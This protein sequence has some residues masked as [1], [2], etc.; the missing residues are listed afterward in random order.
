MAFVM[1]SEVDINHLM[2]KTNI[3]DMS[4]AVFSFSLMKMSLMIR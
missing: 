4:T 2:Q 3:Q 1:P